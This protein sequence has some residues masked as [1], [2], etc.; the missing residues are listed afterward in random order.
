MYI[1]YIVAMILS[2]ILGWN[3]SSICFGSLVG[4]G[5]MKY[6]KAAFIASIGFIV[7]II[8]EGWKMHV[9]IF[10]S[11]P[12]YNEF[13]LS[14][15]ILL[16]ALILFL[17]TF[18]K[19]PISLS[20][21]LIF[22]LIGYSL[23]FN[24]QIFILPFLELIA[25][26]IISPFISFLISYILSNFFIKKILINLIK[27]HFYIT[28]LT[29]VSTFFISY[30]LG[31]NNIGFIISLL[32]HGSKENVILSIAL[33]LSSIIGMLIFGK[34]IVKSVG[35]DIV[36][37]APIKLLTSL[38]STIILIWI[39]T[40]LSFINSLTIN[41]IGA[42]LGSAFSSKLVL[43]NLKYLKKIIEM[44]FVSSFL[45]LSLSYI[46]LYFYHHIMF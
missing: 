7:G 46:V 40:Q 19:I 3:N 8:I 35:E 22:S 36:I 4:M 45:S 24:N 31:A 17:S 21:I 42:L 20:N 29:L 26:W 12:Y 37:V 2:L 44:W 18:L 41:F 15:V 43:F 30:T 33:G 39:S 13:D 38:L 25:W 16:T 9:S 14:I 5:L 34:R 27:S 28:L 10:F 6:K 1:S 11:P 32:L 23:Y